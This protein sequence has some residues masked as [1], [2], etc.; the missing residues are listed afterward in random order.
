MR[1]GITGYPFEKYVA[2]ILQNQRFKTKTNQIIRG[3][4]VTHEVDVV[5][6]NIKKQIYIECKYHNYQGKKCNVKTPLYV[7]ARFMDIEEAYGKNLSLQFEGWLITN[8]RFTADAVQYGHCVGLHLIGWD[9]PTSG[10]L[11]ELIEISGLYPITCISDFTK[12]ELRRLF[13][14][15]IVLCKSIN[16]DPSILDQL[17]ISFLRK[18]IILEQCQ[19]LCRLFKENKDL[20]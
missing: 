6:N 10:S 15:N 11:K 4:C 2:E 7:K 5:A 20:E 9:Y 18:N 3:R 1:L 12:S 16:D 19:Q 14:K 8:A 17:R 13:S